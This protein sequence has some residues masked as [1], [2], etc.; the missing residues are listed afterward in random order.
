[1]KHLKHFVSLFL[2]FCITF[3]FMIPPIAA[4]A[5]GENITIGASIGILGQTVT[6]SG[7]GFSPGTVAQPY[8][9]DILFG[10]G[11]G[12]TLTA[13]NRFSVLRTAQTIN[14]NGTFSTTIAIPSLLGDGT[15]QEAVTSGTYYIFVNYRSGSTGRLS[16]V[17]DKEYF[18]VLAGDLSVAPG[19][20]YA[21]TEVRLSGSGFGSMEALII[22]YD[23]EILTAIAGD[24]ALSNGA[25]S[26]TRIYI[27]ASTAGMHALTVTGASS[28]HQIG[29]IFTVR[30]NILFRPEDAG[31][32]SNKISMYGTG[33]GASVPIEVKFNNVAFYN[34]VTQSNGSFVTEFA[35]HQLPEGNYTV[36]GRDSLSNT[37]QVSYVVSDA[38]VTMEPT[39]GSPAW[40]VL[41]TGDGFQANKPI[42][43]SFEGFQENKNV[44]A[45]SD[46][47]GNFTAVF[48]VPW[49]DKGTWDV[50]ITDGSFTKVLPFEVNTS[51]RINPITSA[52]Q[53][54][55]VGETI[56]IEGT[57]FL[58]GRPL[59]VRFSGTQVMTGQVQSNGTFH[60]EF[61]A[62]SAAGGNHLIEATDGTNTERYGFVME[63]IPPA[64]PEMLVPEAGKKAKAFFDWSDVTDD[65]GVTYTLQVATDTAFTNILLEKTGLAVSE[66]TVLKTE[67]LNAVSKDTPYYWRIKATDQAFNDSSWTAASPFYMSFGF[68]LPQAVIYIIIVVAA[69]GLATFTFWLGR[70]TAYY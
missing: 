42:T 2:A 25:V 32:A 34:G 51:I 7:T 22:R 4:R 5:A 14:S 61:P 70:K 40:D 47:E 46:A 49:A 39:A 33:F 50:T 24:K 26:N 48:S 57:G 9:V 56:A 38:Q 15:V 64:I 69:L 16:P 44:T 36:V 62:P 30:P 52:A 45:T 28:G 20:G 8:T 43:I 65:S 68:S 67:M 1:M 13:S 37:V 60:V 17:I 35:P 6:V 66:Y 12:T 58:A 27:P 63:A 21:G 54:G 23:S 29:N 11:I 3:S 31:I 18:Q 41:I 59:T 10:K 53:P 19:T 55:T